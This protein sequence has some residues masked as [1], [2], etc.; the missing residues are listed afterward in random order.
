M[1]F[2][3]LIYVI[4]APGHQVTMAQKTLS[5]VYTDVKGQLTEYTQ[6]VKQVNAK[7]NLIDIAN[8]FLVDEQR[9][10]GSLTVDVDILAE[11]L[12]ETIDQDTDVI[13]NNDGTID[14]ED[15]AQRQGQRQNNSGT[16]ASKQRN[17]SYSIYP[18]RTKGQECCDAIVLEVGDGGNS[19]GRQCRR[20]PRPNTDGLKQGLCTQHQC[21]QDQLRYSTYSEARGLGPLKPDGDPQPVSKRTE[22]Q[23]MFSDA[24]ELLS[25]N[26]GNDS[27]SIATLRKYINA[28]NAKRQRVYV[29]QVRIGIGQ[30]TQCL[31]DRPP[32][33]TEESLTTLMAGEQEVG[34]QEA[35]EQE[36]L[37]DDS[38]LR[39]E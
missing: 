27:R 20:K 16:P 3:I 36:D 32:T 31:L 17:T 39:E 1:R 22:I 24:V 38:D 19:F 9:N 6:L 14:D 10:T 2:V 28:Q 4:N 11:L 25:K 5:N 34:E 12:R 35:E 13:G 37:C 33:V 8:E 23:S 7:Q 18:K 21:T 26:E 15:L 30:I 29:E